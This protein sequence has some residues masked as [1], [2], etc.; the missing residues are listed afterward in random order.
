MRE[1]QKNKTDLG[2][3]D[4]RYPICQEV[5]GEPDWQ[6]FFQSAYINRSARNVPSV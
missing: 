6:D 4:G 3:R 2:H 1:R 5:L